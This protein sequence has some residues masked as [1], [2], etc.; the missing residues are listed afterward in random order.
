MR[1]RYIAIEGPIG[2]GK[3]VLA[4]RLAALWDARLELE[5][6]DNPFLEAFY[7]DRRG[8][9]FSAQIWFLVTRYR[10][11]LDLIQRDLFHQTTVADY[12]FEKDRIFAFLNLDDTELATYEK[13]YH[14]LAADVPKP[15]LVVYLQAKVPVLAER[16]ARR[17]REV[18]R[19]ISEAYLEE[20]V[21]AYDHFFFRFEE[22]P[23]LVV[24]TNDF[25]PA[26]DATQLD[27]L[28]RRIERMDRGGVEYYRPGG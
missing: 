8:A 9:A 11:Q 17:G 19:R 4:R 23:L 5:P 15:D 27:D 18:E 20:V 7:R 14:L 2:V 22:A 10:R 28:V 21:K 6:V 16:I 24:D 26:H 12:L 3:T 13:L 25:D 1:S